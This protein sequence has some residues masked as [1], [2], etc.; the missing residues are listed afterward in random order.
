MKECVF[1][2]V[3][4]LSLHLPHCQLMIIACLQMCVSVYAYILY[5]NVCFSM[6]AKWPHLINAQTSYSGLGDIKYDPDVKS[7]KY[8]KMCACIACAM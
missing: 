6:F 3:C 4:M 1:K 5:V 7:L 2:C 8:S